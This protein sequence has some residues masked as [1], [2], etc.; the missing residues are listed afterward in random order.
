M[1]GFLVCLGR[2]LMKLW[3]LGC[4]AHCA[5]GITVH[6]KTNHVHGVKDNFQSD[7]LNATFGL[8][9]I[10]LDWECYEI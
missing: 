9:R 6:K 2:Q 1:F 3:S 4:L 7:K 8:E 5:V 10:L